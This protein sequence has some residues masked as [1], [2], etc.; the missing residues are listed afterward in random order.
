[1]SRPTF[2]PTTELRAKVK[3]LAAHGAPQ[4]EIATLVGCSAKTLRKYFRRELDQGAAEALAAVAAKL[5]ELVQAGNV[6]AQIFWHKAQGGARTG[7]EDGDG[8]N[9]GRKP[10]GVIIVIPDNGRDPEINQGRMEIWAEA[11]RL[12]IRDEARKARDGKRYRTKRPASVS[13]TPREDS[14]EPQTL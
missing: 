1:M 6:T 4:D 9:V 3:T 13:T 5:L 11:E 7:A 10:P 2:K 8:G 14:D 12:R